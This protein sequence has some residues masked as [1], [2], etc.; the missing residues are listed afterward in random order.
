MKALTFQ[1]KTTA[2]VKTIPLPA[3]R[4]TH[5]LIKVESVA[6][7]PTDWKC[8]DS[9]IAATPF[10]IVGCDYSGTVV[11]IG[12]EVTKPFKIG[13]KVYGCAHGSNQNE[14]Y[15]GVFA[16]YT[17]VKGD[18]TMH[19][20]TNPNLSM[21]DLCTIPLCSITVGQGLFQPGGKSLGLAL[22]ETGNGKEEWVLIYGGSTTAGCLG[23]QF[24][25]LAGY[26]V[27]T[28][29]SPRNNDLV[30]SR[31]AD[32]I[33]DYND[34]ESASKINKLTENKLRYAWDTIAE[35]KFCDEALSSDAPDCHYGCILFDDEKVLREGVKCTET[36]MYT[37]FGE[38]FQ[39]YETDWPASKEDYEFA[40]TWMSL[41]EKLV[42]EGKIMP[43]PKKV[44]HGGLEAIPKGMEDLMAEKV[45]GEK[46]V[47][48]LH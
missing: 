10:S 18:V 9:G 38:G 45:R 36:L 7:N 19:A 46:L 29:C 5:L 1:A 14:A 6:L 30:K 26:K 37:M 44:M 20:P 34:P 2:S 24:A 43:H 28:T 12:S 4:P 11:S 48:P 39:K 3:L 13:D 22:P 25:K 42:A 47:Y 23:I 16:E 32:E 27:I 35:S 31:G 40:K 8:V 33:F 15:D 41:T 17:M 21:E